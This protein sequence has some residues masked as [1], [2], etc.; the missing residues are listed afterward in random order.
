MG[1]GSREKRGE[2]KSFAHG[3]EKGEKNFSLDL[4][5]GNGRIKAYIASSI[6]YSFYAAVPKSSLANPFQPS[7]FCS[8]ND[9]ELD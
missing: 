8:F 4:L 5:T 7:W 9:T 1:F 2:N 3:E 6:C